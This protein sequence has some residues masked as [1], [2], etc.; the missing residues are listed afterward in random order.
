MKKIW[1]LMV[2]VALFAQETTHVVKID[3]TLW[4]IADIYYQ[5]PFL[6]PYIWR[7][8]LTK[9]E[10]P[11]WIYPDQ[12]FVIPPHPEGEVTEYVPEPVMVTTPP[13]KKTAE[14]ISFVEP[15][16]R[17]FSEEIIHRAGFILEEDIPFWGKITGTEPQGEKLITSY[18]KV[19]IDRSEDIQVGDVLTIYRPGMTIKHPKTGDFL[20]KEVIV[21]GRA[22]IEE[23]GNEGSRAKVI[24]SYDIIKNGD[25]VIPYE[26]IFAPI[27]I[28]MVATEEDIEG[29]VVEVKDAG[30][31]TPPH[32]FVYIDH[33][34]ET[35]CA[36]GDIFDVYQERVVG[37][38]EMP[39]FNI[40][41]IQVI[42]V[43]QK[44]SIGLLL[45][46]RETT[47]VKRG[48]KIRLAMEAR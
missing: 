19:Y 41:K 5:N 30:L 33:G 46:V 21:L 15:D 28:E 35:G 25:L 26:P 44:A 9:I 34:E 12:L 6:W 40:A 18:K 22:E 14:V 1:I 36:V 17:I 8:N 32:V 31:S 42:S 7:A 13:A 39:D 16:R 43:F 29:Y 23:I 38:K 45:N 2:F 20:G 47:Q 10:D 27:S 4:D 37:G 11:H 48:E 3:D 24:A